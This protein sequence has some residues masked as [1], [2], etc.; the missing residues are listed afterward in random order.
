MNQP[1]RTQQ[2]NG[3]PIQLPH[4]AGPARVGQGTA[5]E[6]SRAQSEVYFRV[7]LAHDKPRDEDVVTAAMKRAC[8]RLHLAEKAFY[9]L[10]RG[11]DRN[12]D[13]QTVE[14][15]SVHLARELARIWGNI[16][17]GAKELRQDDEYAQSEIEAH[18]WD[19]ETNARSS[20]TFIVPHKKDTKTGVRK[21]DTMQSIYENNANNAA[22]RVREAIFAVLPQWFV[23][24]AQEAC[25]A[26]LAKGDG[27]PLEERIATAIAVF[28]KDF[29]VTEEQLVAK[30]G[31]SKDRW[32]EQDVAGLSVTYK[33]LK[34][35]EVTKEQE[36]PAADTKVTADEL[37][38]VDRSDEQREFEAEEGNR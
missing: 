32:D 19:L 21:L 6:Q 12:G 18:A 22:K 1:V 36:F 3:A 26:T 24:E 25:R 34:A 10:P 11:K 15:P 35:R 17:Y 23:E 8:N 4:A 7:A 28:K 33:S 30:L 20:Q 13:P 14:G 2:G 31:R 27:T 29:G 16:D 5:V 9:K 38:G 37:A